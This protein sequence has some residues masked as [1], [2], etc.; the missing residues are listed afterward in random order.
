MANLISTE[1]TS[2]RYILLNSCGIQRFYES[3]GVCN[4]PDGRVDYQLLYI[5]EG[6]CLV[7]T[8][9]ATITVDRGGIILYRP[10]VPQRYRLLCGE[11]TISFYVHFTG[12]GCEEIMSELGLSELFVL[13]IGKNPS[14]ER[15]FER[16]LAEYSTM[17]P[18][19]EAF[20]AAYLQ[21]LFAMI[22]RLSLYKERN[23]EEENKRRVDEACKAASER[24]KTVTVSELA[25]AAHLSVGRFSAIF[26]ELMGRS[27]GDYIAALRIER[28]KDL[29][30]FGTMSVG[31]IAEAVGYSDQNYF[32][33][34]FKKRV[35]VSPS[36]YRHSPII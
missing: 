22:S 30:C 27:V 15:V 36:I 25:E 34:A 9:N 19:Y 11:R 13:N 6:R 3:D 32:S 31:E 35:G 21:E 20:T 26:R 33:R 1:R 4:R 28:A 24:L 7:Y 12:R 14:Y 29:L 10:G 23:F 17:R 5:A 2:D 8:E 16:L 18:C